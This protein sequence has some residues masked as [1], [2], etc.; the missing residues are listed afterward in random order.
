MSFNIKYILPGDDKNQITSKV[1]QNFSQVYYAGVGLQGERGVV[2]PT[3]IIGQVGKNGASGP[4]GERANI[5]IFQNEP[6]GIYTPYPTPLENY[7]VWVNTSPTGSTGG[8]NRIYRFDSTYGGGDFGF[9]WIDTG[10]NFVSGDIFTLI[11]GISGPPQIRDRNAIVPGSTATFVFLDSDVSPSNANPTYSKVLIG[12]R[13]FTTAELPVLGFDKTFY[14][15]SGPPSF[16]WQNTTDYSI[17]FSSSQDISI[18]SQATGTYSS[19]GG[20]AGA[21]AAENLTVASSTTMGI[22]GPSGISIVSGSPLGVQTPNFS[23]SSFASLPSVNSGVTISSSTS[24]SIFSVENNP[25]LA[26]NDTRNLTVLDFSGGPSGGILKPNVDLKMAGN[27]L[28]RINNAASGSYPTLSIGYTGST[29]F[30]G[31]SGGTGSNVYKTFQTVTSNALS[32]TT[33]AEAPSS[34]YIIVTLDSDVIRVVP[35][36]PTGSSVSSN[37]RNGRIWLYLT[38]IP[39]YVESG[40]SSQVDIFMDSLEYSIGGIA[41]QTNFSYLYGDYGEYKIVD[42]GTGPEEGC[43][44]VR[45][46]FFGDEFPSSVNNTGNKYSQIQ[47]YMGYTGGGINSESLVPYYYAVT[48][49]GS[50]TVLT[51]ICTELYSQGYMSD[52]IREADQKYGKM[53]LET[54]PE[55]MIG[56]HYW[57]TPIVGLMKKSK[58]FTDLVWIFAKPWSIQMAYEMGAVDKGNWIGK[59]LMK[60]GMFFSGMIGRRLIKKLKLKNFRNL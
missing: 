46:N 31:P 20:S 49:T 8:L 52:S 34:N 24:G 36:V 19:T 9:F 32:K 12:N 30:T 23:L 11:Q 43:R 22:T 51:V 55:V 50:G 45:V 42:G 44:H 16:F 2:G 58:I 41:L 27:S 35:A 54:L 37:G 57:A 25:P 47:A 40:N 17:E 28:F 38:G 39:E 4:T 26:D 15:E 7:D 29:G 59:L 21:T 5:W 33:F 6:P 56:Y 53:I 18:S 10:E 3:G 60:V 48:S 13:G 1:N 14:T